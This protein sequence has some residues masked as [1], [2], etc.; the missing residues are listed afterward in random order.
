MDTPAATGSDWNPLISYD[1]VTNDLIQ[2]YEAE[3]NK[4]QVNMRKK[5]LLVH[6]RAESNSSM[7]AWKG[8]V[9]VPEM[10]VEQ[11]RCILSHSTSCFI[12]L[13]CQSF[14]PTPPHPPQP[15]RPVKELPPWLDQEPNLPHRRG[16]H[17]DITP[18]HPDWAVPSSW[19]C[20]RE[21]FG[22]GVWD[23]SELTTPPSCCSV[24]LH[25]AHH[26]ICIHHEPQRWKQFEGQHRCM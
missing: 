16:C 21:G 25:R 4:Q 18:C 5:K 15:L 19:R 11:W 22:A 7:K 14:L 12:G 6:W 23:S 1:S 10:F 3:I 17:G 2:V 26:S 24:H 8:S 13:A 20:Q 9:C